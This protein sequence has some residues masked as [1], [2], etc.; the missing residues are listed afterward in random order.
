MP[1]RTCSGL[2][3]ILVLSAIQVSGTIVSR[4]TFRLGASVVQMRHVESGEK[5]VV[6][7][8]TGLVFIAHHS[9]SIYVQCA[10]AHRRCRSDCRGCHRRILCRAHASR[11]HA[12]P[13]SQDFGHPAYRL[14]DRKRLPDF[15][16]DSSKTSSPSLPVTRSGFFSGVKAAPM[17]WLGVLWCYTAEDSVPVN[18]LVPQRSTDMKKDNCRRQI[19]QSFVD[20]RP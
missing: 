15:Y 1:I 6:G 3:R 8:V 13:S 19:R 7:E 5:K 4:T 9:L 10:A 2:N 14:W 17:V 18:E 20:I 12:P 11:Q 16:A